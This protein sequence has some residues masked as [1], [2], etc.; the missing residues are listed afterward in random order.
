VPHPKVKISDDAG[1]T[2][3]V[4]TSSNALH[5]KLAESID[6]GMLGDVNIKLDGTNVS[7]G[8]DDIDTG[9]IRVTLASN[10]TQFGEIGDDAAVAGN[11]HGQLR[12]IGNALASQSTIASNTGGAKDALNMA[13]S[14]TGGEYAEGDGGFIATGV[15]N[16]T[17]ASLVSVDHDH[18][19]FQV[20]A[21]GALYV[22]SG[23]D[24]DDVVVANGMQIMAEA[25]SIDGSTLP[26]TT[27]E[28]D[29]IRIAATR[30]GVLY[31][32]LSSG[33]GLKS[34][35]IDDDDEQVSTPSMVNVGG[36]YRAVLGTYGNGDATILQSDPKGRLR[37][38]GNHVD[39]DGF[40]LGSDSG[41]MIM[42]FAGTQNVDT[43]DAAALQCDG[44]GRLMVE[45]DSTSIGTG[46][47]FR[48]NGEAWDNVDIGVGV[49]AVRNDTLVA[50]SNV[51]DGDYTPFQV[52]AEGAL[53]TT[54]GVTGG[55]DGVTTDDTNGT[56]LGGDVICQK[57]DIQAQTDN[58]GVIAVGF[59]GVDATIATGTG[60]IL[61]P[62]DTYSLEINNLNLIYI[63]SSVNGEGVRY[64][65]FT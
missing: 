35:I 18:A 40:T 51:A 45:I 25:K 65:Y 61:Y 37:I 4:D 41:I 64:T 8:A 34:P 15:R 36:E 24:H 6:V 55:A 49:Y 50:L 56:V 7:A 43:N 31:S 14:T 42:G 12:Y 22:T 11:I 44:S 60:I 21:S 33:D 13:V 46:T 29:A 30:G 54:H 23:A 5:V 9:T 3:A 20:N 38:A 57:I 16:D 17:L 10:D 19:P 59:T 32:T 2:V 47:C 48:L 62:G 1:N 58:T 28:G 39:D 27:A 26:N 53:Y 52:D 63:E